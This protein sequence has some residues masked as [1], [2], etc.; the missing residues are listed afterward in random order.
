MK[1]YFSI[2]APLGRMSVPLLAAVTI[3]CSGE[4]GGSGPDGNV[5]GGTLDRQAPSVPAE[6]RAE[7]RSSSLVDISWSPS[8]DNVGVSGYRVTRDGAV[9]GETAVPPYS[10]GGLEAGATY[11]YRVCAFDTSGNFSDYSSPATA[12][13][14]GE[15]V[16]LVGPGREHTALQ[17]VVPMLSP[18]DIVL[19]DGGAVYS[20]GITF[21]A[22]G[23]P[24]NPVI[25]RGVAGEAGRPVLEGGRNVV[26]F[27]RD[28]YV[29]EGFEIRGA[30]FR[31]LYHHADDITIRDCVVH[32]CPHGILGADQGSGDLTI[33]YCEVYSCGEGDGR[34]QLYIATNQN[35]F[36]GS[37]F[38]MRFCWIHDG[39][40]GNNVKSRAERNEI[41]YNR[42]ENP[43]YHNLELIGP[44]QTSGVAEDRAR[45][46]SDVVGNVLVAR[47]YPRNVRIGGDA[48]T[49]QSEG[50]YRF[51]FNTFVHAGAYQ[52]SHIF[53]HFGV[54]S[55]EMS[56]NVF[57]LTRGVVLDDSECD[58]AAGRRV[59]GTRNW[60]HSSAAFPAEW[61]G[62]L[63]GP[64]PGLVDIQ[65]LQLEPAPGSPLIDAGT[66]AAAPPEGFAVPDPLLIPLFH[67]PGPALLPPGTGALRA[68]IGQIDIGAYE[69]E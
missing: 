21:Q 23:L 41:Y 36:P 24:G 8:T 15:N 38:R 63:R 32:D 18:G 49:Q 16:Y 64:D 17:D 37:V 59:G 20:G 47:R 33:E 44:D 52:T 61:T 60:V 27:D 40:G 11:S 14:P 29:F 34:H 3:S 51:A 62:T 25:I 2:L 56:N 48:A 42:L 53:C 30:G 55:V 67:P 9:A 66:T 1:T 57:Y 6:V 43:Y 69:A 50:R 26:E 39:T 45:E 19:V 65:D 12:V 28:H 46:D 10:D 54:E 13:T 31:G 68:I 22:A 35:D 58:W 4:D 5:E 7:P